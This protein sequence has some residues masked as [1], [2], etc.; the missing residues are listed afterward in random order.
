MLDT[1][2]KDL[3]GVDRAKFVA[4]IQACVRGGLQGVW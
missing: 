1:Y 4:C 2:P 3:G